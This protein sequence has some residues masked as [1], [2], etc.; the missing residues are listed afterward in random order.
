MQTG[1][2]AVA[3]ISGGLT[4]AERSEALAALTQ[5]IAAII[6]APAGRVNTAHLLSI[7]AEATDAVKSQITTDKSRL[8]QA[9][10]VLSSGVQAIGTAPQAYNA[11]QA[12]LALL[13]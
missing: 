1:D 4:P 10:D 5:A 13:T 2:G 12:V 7:A 8:R 6:A 9:F 3:S 11:I